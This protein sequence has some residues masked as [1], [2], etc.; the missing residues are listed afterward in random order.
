MSK[1]EIPSCPDPQVINPLQVTGFDFKISKFPSLSFWAQNVDIP[2]ITL[3]GALSSNPFT[4]IELVGDKPDFDSITV[5]FKVDEKMNNYFDLIQWINLIGFSTSYRDIGQ[6]REKW[7]QFPQFE[8]NTESTLTSP[9]ILSIKG[10]NK[11]TVRTITFDSI[12]PT[13][14]GPV[15]LTEETSDTQY[16]TCSATFKFKGPF[17]ISEC[18][19]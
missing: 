6:W 4:N 17:E 19:V 7:K 3:S 5:T 12:W 14:I 10:P 15:S 2:G 1:I 9:A 8:G 18:M 13:A 11:K 16:A